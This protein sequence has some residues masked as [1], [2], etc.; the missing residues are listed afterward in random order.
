MLLLSACGFVWLNRAQIAALVPLVRSTPSLP[1]GGEPLPFQVPPGFTARLFSR[2]TPGVRTL[3]RD[4][5]GTLV[6]S[7]T[8][9][10]RVVALPDDDGDGVADSVVEVVSGLYGPHGLAFVCSERSDAGCL[11][12]IAE[13]D[14][15]RSYSYDEATRKALVKETLTILP[16]SGGH[17]TRSLALHPDGKRLLVSVGSSCNACEEKDTRRAA[18]LAIDLESMETRRFAWGLRNTVFMRVHPQT[19]EIWGTDMGRD[20]LGDDVPPEEVNIIREG[21]WYG[22]PWFYGA[23]TKDLVFSR[24]VPPGFEQEAIPAHI[25][26]QAHSAPL[27]LDFIPRKGWPEEFHNDLIVAFHGSWN[28]TSPTGYKLV[29]I[30]LDAS[31]K[32]SGEISDFMT[33]FTQGGNI[34]GRPV[35]VLVEPNGVIYVSDDRAGGIYRISKD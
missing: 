35:D 17:S 6:A 34:L 9:D 2:D 25:E 29:R 24:D 19:S 15:V 12:Y 28:R 4:P 14:A 3:V 5:R 22:W 33:G 30:E 13:E 23:N 31:G 18:V 11:L 26:M 32:P 8:K 16:S 20:L 1:A 7:L 21:A 10:G 27:G